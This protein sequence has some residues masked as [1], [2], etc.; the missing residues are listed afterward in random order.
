[1]A[2][3]DLEAV[4]RDADIVS[5]EEVGTGTTQPKLVTLASNGALYR[6]IYKTNELL[7]E[8]AIDDAG[9][10]VT[11]VSHRF[12][13]EVA[14]YRVAELLGLDQVPATVVRRINGHVGSLQL[15]VENAVSERNRQDEDLQPL[16]PESFERQRALVSVFDVLIHNLDRNSTNLLVTTDDWRLW[17][18]DHAH[19]FAYTVERPPGLEEEDLLLDA[20]LVESLR[21][22]DSET[23]RDELEGLLD[24][25]QIDAMLAR[26]DLIVA[27]WQ[28][29]QPEP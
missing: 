8:G 10:L 25:A 18:I 7:E 27:A 4:L 13:H 29:G 22:L 6:G 9:H 21:S 20:D 24:D 3:A 19:A 16:D 15:W 1:M 17:M 28:D 2:A 23:L 12:E 14:A 5:I 26:R 11:T